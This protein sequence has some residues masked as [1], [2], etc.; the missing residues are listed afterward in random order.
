MLLF[1]FLIC[2]EC[3]VLNIIRQNICINQEFLKKV[4]KNCF[5]IFG[6]IDQY[7]AKNSQKIF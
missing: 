7:K 6:T 5:E 4:Y 3:G 2:T 1:R